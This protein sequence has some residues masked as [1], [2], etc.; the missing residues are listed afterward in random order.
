MDGEQRTSA[1]GSG[2][3]K[4]TLPL[5]LQGEWAALG[6]GK[7]KDQP[8]SKEEAKLFAFLKRLGEEADSQLDGKEVSHKQC[9]Y[10]VLAV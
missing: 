3:R 4:A 5:C 8:A 2:V 9:Q 6:E 7:E 10:A 1:C